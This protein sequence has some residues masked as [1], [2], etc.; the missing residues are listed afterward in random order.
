MQ[1]FFDKVS[2]YGLLYTLKYAF[3]NH[4]NLLRN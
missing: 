2:V 4:K 3:A 1:I